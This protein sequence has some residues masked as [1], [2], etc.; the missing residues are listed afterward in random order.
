MPHPLA[1]TGP[2]GRPHR[3]NPGLRGPPDRA[4]GAQ[5]NSSQLPALSG[6]LAPL[7]PAQPVPP[8]RRRANA[9]S[10]T[11]SLGRD[12]NPGTARVPSLALASRSDSPAVV[13]GAQVFSNALLRALSRLR[14]R[15]TVERMD[16]EAISQNMNQGSGLAALVDLLRV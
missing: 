12:G 13:V 10:D 8:A 4:G 6:S 14:M 9:M 16:A 1:S 3:V 15:E 11:T 7:S 5:R 2:T